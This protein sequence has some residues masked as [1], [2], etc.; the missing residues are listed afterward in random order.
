MT[1]LPQPRAALSPEELRQ[2]LQGCENEAIHIPGAI[3]PHGVMLVLHP[4]SFTIIQASANS[5][6]LIGKSAEALL[7]Q[8]VEAV[9]GKTQ[10][11][12]LKNTSPSAVNRSGIRSGVMQIG[13][14]IFDAVVHRNEGGLILEL[15][16]STPAD[17]PFSDDPVGSGAFFSALRGASLALQQALSADS[18]SQ[19]VVDQVRELTGFDRV[20]LYQFE[21]DW[22]GKVVAESRV[23]GMA[24]YLGLHFPDSDIPAQARTLYARNPLRLIADTR[25]APAPLLPARNP[26]SGGPLDMSDSILRSV[27]PVHVE[28]LENM[29]VRA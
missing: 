10:T 18:L 8:P 22:S 13:G 6:V 21:D 26:L 29:R 9:I 5:D 11:E 20:M 25:Y 14:T 23:A 12:L 4:A 3:Q 7:G 24:S 28:Y 16:P 1:P 15:E 17:S 27:S 19:L 2:A